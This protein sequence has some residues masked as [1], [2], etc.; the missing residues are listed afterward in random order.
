M[1]PYVIKK[2]EVVASRRLI[3]SIAGD[4]HGNSRTKSDDSGH[5]SICGLWRLKG[6]TNDTRYLKRVDPVCLM[7]RKN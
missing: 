7:Q 4:I 6:G 1:I 5:R 3:K 2:M